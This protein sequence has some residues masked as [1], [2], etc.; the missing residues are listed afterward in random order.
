VLEKFGGDPPL[1][2]APYTASKLKQMKLASGLDFNV[3]VNRRLLLTIIA[4][5][6]AFAFRKQLGGVLSDVAARFK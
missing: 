6:A 4:V 1:R 2:F 3:R 5:A